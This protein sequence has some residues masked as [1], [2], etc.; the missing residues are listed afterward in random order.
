MATT[1]TPAAAWWCR[2]GCG[3]GPVA[4]GIVG[5]LAV[6]TLVGAAARPYYY[7]PPPYYYYGPPPYGPGP[8]GPP[9]GSVARCAAG[10]H[11]DPK[12][13]RAGQIEPMVAGRFLR[14]SLL[15]G[16]LRF[17]CGARA[18]LR[19][20]GLAHQRRRIVPPVGR[21]LELRTTA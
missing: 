2:W 13:A 15:P 11:L 3:P 6:G 9:P 16:S 18:L 7:Y 4:A 1:A 21:M 17:S 8:Y 14:V 10:Y 12:A 19:S 5:G 20:I